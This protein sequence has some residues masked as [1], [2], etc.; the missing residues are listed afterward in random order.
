[1]S[2]PDDEAA[3][4]PSGWIGELAAVAAKFL[5]RR[6]VKFAVVG[7][8]GMV[9]NMAALF[10]FADLASIHTNLASAIAIEISVLSNFALNDRWTFADR[11]AAAS[12]GLTRLIR[13]HAVSGVGATVQWVTFVVGNYLVASLLLGDG[14]SSLGASFSHPPEVG[15]WKYFSQFVGVGVAAVWNFLAN[16]KWT[17]RNDGPGPAAE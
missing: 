6:F 11:R 5:P 9:V 15:A 1:M 3:R 10:V 17:W 4:L 12:G 2:T 14:T 8:S 13:F 16:L 7:V